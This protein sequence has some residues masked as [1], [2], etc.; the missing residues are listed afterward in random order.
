MSNVNF[1]EYENLFSN[2]LV[3]EEQ[4]HQQMDRTQMFLQQQQLYHQSTQSQQQQQQQNSIPIQIAGNGQSINKPDSSVFSP[5]H[6]QQN[7]S[8]HTSRFGSFVSNSSHFDSEVNFNELNDAVSSINSGILS[9]YSTGSS[10]DDFFLSA[11]SSNVDSQYSN[12]DNDFNV[13]L[14][15]NTHLNNDVLYP[16]QFLPVPMAESASNS[17]VTFNTNDNY[18]QQPHLQTLNTVDEAEED[19]IKKETPPSPSL[20]S[21]NNNNINNGDD[22]QSLTDQHLKPGRKV[23]SS[24]NLI[25]KKYRTNINSKIIELRNCVPALRILVAKNGNHRTR[26]VG[27]EA[28]ETD[29]YYEGDGYSDDEE[30][31]DGLKPA[32]KLNKATILAKASEYIRHLEKKNDVLREQNFQLRKLLDA[33]GINIGSDQ[34][35]RPP[36]Q[37]YPL[38]PQSTSLR[39]SPFNRSN[40][41][42]STGNGSNLV[43]PSDPNYQNQQL[44]DHQSLTNKILLGSIGS[45][46]GATG[47]DDFTTGSS[48][49]QRGL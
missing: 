49:N 48:L 1:D 39:S 13:D 31:L 23:K 24:H 2:N 27:N 18:H 3:N 43:S 40:N 36:P 10:P 42:N 37:F 32:K 34:Y 4:Q 6:N 33:S 25:E 5:N 45:M 46:L 8:G 30:K 9:P 11:T 35:I 7:Q 22:F 28:E 19:L 15:N 26:N 44:P 12:D 29:D 14:N 41:S 38:P 21:E 20:G 16:Q 47:L 17:T